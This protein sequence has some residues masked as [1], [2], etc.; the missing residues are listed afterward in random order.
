MPFFCS[1]AR[2]SLYMDYHFTGKGKDVGVAMV[3]KLQNTRYSLDEKLEKSFINLFGRGPAAQSID[4]DANGNVISA[5]QDDQGDANVFEQVDGTNITNADTMDSDGHSEC[6]SDSEGDN[7]DDI[8]Q[9][10]HDVEL[11]EEVEFC[12]GRLRRKA[13]S[14]NF[15][16]ID[17]EV[18]YFS[19]SSYQ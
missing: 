4:S 8:Q 11:R 9:R 19:L 10:D 14:S 5:S 16:D 13:V 15:Q 7:D 2:L 1:T 12:N 18:S 6:S 3:Q 17:D